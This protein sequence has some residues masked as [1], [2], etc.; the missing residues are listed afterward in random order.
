MQ[1][2]RGVETNKTKETISPRHNSLLP[3]LPQSADTLARWN[4]KRHRLPKAVHERIQQLPIRPVM[5]VGSIA[6]VQPNPTALPGLAP[7]GKMELFVSL[8]AL[9][10]EQDLLVV[11]GPE[12]VRPSHT[13][14]PPTAR[15]FLTT[16]QLARDCL[17]GILANR[18]EEPL[19]RRRY[20]YPRFFT[21]KSPF[22]LCVKEC[23][24]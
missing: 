12:V 8:P 13:L 17:V 18:L 2:H 20:H 7:N 10:E 3:R 16:S 22:V 19:R 4:R 21:H 1:A 23:T 11:H 9:L 5:R 15:H 24:Q 6:S 14:H